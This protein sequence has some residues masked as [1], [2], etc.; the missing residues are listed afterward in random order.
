M[1]QKWNGNDKF[2]PILASGWDISFFYIL[3]SLLLFYTVILTIV[4]FRIGGTR[5]LLATFPNTN[6][7]ALLMFTTHRNRN[8][9]HVLTE[10]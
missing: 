10:K 6:V 3:L 8:G 5:M 7:Y 1:Y 9:L 2:F 4:I